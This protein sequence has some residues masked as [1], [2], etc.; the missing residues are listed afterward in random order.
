MKATSISTLLPMMLHLADLR[1]SQA[2]DLQRC[3]LIVM[4]WNFVG[5]T[6]EQI[7]QAREDWMKCRS[8]AA[9]S[10]LGTAPPRAPPHPSVIP[11][12]RPAK[13]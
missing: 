2:A 7:R 10:P 11:A 8:A 12:H 13:N 6:G 4:W 5:R 1:G 9:T 3:S